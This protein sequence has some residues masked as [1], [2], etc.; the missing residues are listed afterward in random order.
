[1]ASHHF[2]GHAY[3]IQATQGTIF[4]LPPLKI[5]GFSIKFLMAEL[6]YDWHPLMLSQKGVLSNM[7]FIHSFT[8]YHLLSGAENAPRVAAW[9][10]Q[11]DVF[12]KS[13]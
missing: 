5:R 7:E 9:I 8:C 3:G 11:T 1:M 6:A 4:P 10:E 12:T 2:A 13:P